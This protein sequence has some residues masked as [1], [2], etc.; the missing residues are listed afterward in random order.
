MLSVVR[1][2]ATL[3]ALCCLLTLVSCSPQAQDS[4]PAPITESAVAA[5]VATASVMAFQLGEDYEIVREKGSDKPQIVEHFSLYCVHCYHSEELF[6]ELKAGLAEEVDFKRSHVLFLPQSKPDWARNMTFSFAAARE[7]GIE[8]EFV[9]KVFDY[10]FKDKVYLGN[11]DDIKNI[12]VVLGKTGQ[13]FDLALR[14]EAS[15]ITVKSMDQQAKN[16]KVRFTPD[17]IVND[18]Y[19]VKLSGLKEHGDEG[20]R[21]AKLVKYLL[22][23]P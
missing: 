11:I 2:K 1:I 20:K 17:L 18:K 13:E 14:S 23:N 5:T 22:T 4:A 7:L 3:L 10:H 16:D 8:D 6:S 9:A 19:R 15:L 12:F 21:L